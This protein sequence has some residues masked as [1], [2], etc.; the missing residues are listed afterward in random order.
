MNATC[1]V[2]TPDLYTVSPF[3]RLVLFGYSNQMCNFNVTVMNISIETHIVLMCKLYS[4]VAYTTE[5]HRQN[6]ML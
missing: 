6:A 1:P 5:N 3:D 2:P 4:E